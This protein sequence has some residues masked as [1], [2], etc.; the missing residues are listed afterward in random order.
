M[1]FKNKFLSLVSG[2]SLLFGVIAGN[3]LHCS[4]MDVSGK[5]VKTVFL[6]DTGVGK[7]SIV[8][9]LVERD[10]NS[11]Q[12]STIGAQHET[13]EEYYQNSLL[14]VDIWDTAGQERY[15]ALAPMYMRD[16]K[17]AVVVL[18]LNDE[19]TESNLKTWIEFAKRTEP[20]IVFTLVG[21]KQD[22]CG[23]DC[24][25][26]VNLLAENHNIS[27]YFVCSAL[28]GLGIN[29]LKG[30]LF[31]CCEQL[32]DEKKPKENLFEQYDDDLEFEKKSCCK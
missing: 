32:G 28:S 16:A 18:D 24:E 15:R 4:A 19:R 29:E 27:K 20:G 8:N 5:K 3:Q 12:V 7:T 1:N 14:K 2:V 13:L 10:F 22:L 23:D 26:R 9:R 17:L 25:K 21:N 30:Y 31:Q 6:G 11:D